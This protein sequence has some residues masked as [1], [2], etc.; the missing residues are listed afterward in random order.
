MPKQFHIP[1]IGRCLQII[2]FIIMLA[3]TPGV[4]HS[5]AP[6]VSSQPREFITP[7]RFGRVTRGPKLSGVFR[8]SYPT[9]QHFRFLKSLKLRTILTLT[10]EPPSTDLVRFAALCNVTV[11]HIQAIHGRVCGL[12][13]VKINAYIFYSDC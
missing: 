8:G 2:Y 4:M 9:L 5:S 7:L 3:N 13:D 6:A 10:P 11:I 1:F 12:F